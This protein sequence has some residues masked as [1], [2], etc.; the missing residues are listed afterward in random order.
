MW[1]RIAIAC[2][3][4][5]SAAITGCG[6]PVFSGHLATPEVHV[7]NG[8]DVSVTPEDQARFHAAK[9]LIMEL[10]YAEA[11]DMLEDLM[12][13]FE[14]GGSFNCAAESIFWLGYCAE[15]LSRP[16]DAVLR[17]QDVRERYP[18]TRAAEQAEIRMAQIGGAGER[19]E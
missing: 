9:D 16:T 1:A 4:V 14:Q 18:N 10:K 3:F 8:A 11:E 19:T 6:S 12:K 2:L 17:Y 13:K 7:R 15:K 5:V